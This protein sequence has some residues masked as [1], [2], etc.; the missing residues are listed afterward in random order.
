LL[1]GGGVTA[2]CLAKVDRTGQSASSGNI[3]SFLADFSI[4]L[5]ALAI[6]S[7]LNFIGFN[8]ATLEPHLRQ[9]ELT[10]V[11]VGSI[12]ILTG[13]VYA[14]TSPIFG[15]LC[16]MGFNEKTLMLMGCIVCVIGSLFIGPLPFF[17]FEPKLWMIIVSLIIIGLG[18]SA[19]LVTGFV[20]AITHS[21]KRRGLPD[22]MTTYG[23]VSAMFFSSCSVGAFI[24]PILGGVLLDYFD[25]RQASYYILFVD[26]VLAI[27]L[28]TYKSLRCDD[29]R[30]APGEREPL[31]RRESRTRIGSV[32]SAL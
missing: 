8:A 31:I 28:I 19:K 11:I 3:F 9:F 22:D 1:V 2:C 30:V 18:I 21:I 14:V 15:K 24:G 17:S 20:D 26:V 6:A 4:L 7:S 13:T 29:I 16:D 5:D 32:P 27:C 23:M 10:P 12:F 25:Y